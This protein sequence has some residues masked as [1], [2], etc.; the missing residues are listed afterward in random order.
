[1]N[2]SMFVQLRYMNVWLHLMH[3]VEIILSDVSGVCLTT[4]C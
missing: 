2:S 4:L 3:Q 1:M